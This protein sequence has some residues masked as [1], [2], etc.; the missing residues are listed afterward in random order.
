MDMLTISSMTHSI[1]STFQYALKE[2]S[3]WAIPPVC[4]NCEE[5]VSSQLDMAICEICQEV[6]WN[7]PR[8]I[9]C[10]H[11][12]HPSEIGKKRCH[13]CKKIVTPFTHCSSLGPYRQWLRKAIVDLK[14]KQCK[15]SL[16]YLQNL[17]C[18]WPTPEPAISLCYVPSHAKRLKQRGAKEQHLAQICE[19]YMQQHQRE[20]TRLLEKINFT[21]AQ[22]DLNGEERR[23][24]ARGTFRYIGPMPAPQCVWLFDDVYTTGST[25]AAACT[26]LREAGVNDIR[27]FTLASPAWE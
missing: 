8:C 6:Q 3:T 21:R 10:G 12:C 1:L 24:A 9:R 16:R 2:W 15:L 7:M 19:K 5:P 22:V 20:F 18:A 27:V 11:R 4:L 25:I 13:K 14:Y 23:L 26:A 17:C